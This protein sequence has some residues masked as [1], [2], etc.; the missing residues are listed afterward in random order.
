MNM[1][2]KGVSIT[3]VIYVDDL[4]LVCTDIQVIH[5]VIG[6]LKK[7]YG[8]VITA[9]GLI[10]SYLGLVID[11]TEAPIVTLNQTGM[12]ED[13]ITSTKIAVDTA[14]SDGSKVHLKVGPRI[15]PKTPAPA[16]LFNT[17]EGKEPLC[18]SFMTIFH[19][20][21]AKLIFLTNRTRAHILTAVS[22]WLNVSSTPPRKTE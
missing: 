1:T 14:R 22:F 20:V 5:A 16:Y 7:R 9:E 4:L 6:A 3:V 21:V 11:F 18:D 2:A 19:T 17:T 8:E 12:I 13:I 15:T 10:H